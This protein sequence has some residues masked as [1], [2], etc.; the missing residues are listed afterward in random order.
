MTRL[1]VDVRALVVGDR[2]RHGEHGGLADTERLVG[3]VGGIEAVGA[4]GVEGQ[5]G[6]G[7]AV[8][9]EGQ[10]RIGVNVGG[11]DRTGQERGILGDADAGG[12]GH[13]RVVGAGDGDDQVGGGHGALVV[14]DQVRHGEHG[15][16]AD[17]Q[18]LVGR[19]GGIE[20]VGAVSVEGQAGR[21]R[22]IEREGQRRIGIDV[23]GDDR[24]GQDR[25]ILGDADAG[26]LGHRRVVGAGDGDDQVGGER[27]AL[28][29]GDR[30]RHGE[31]GGL[32]DTQRLVGR[33][34]GIEAVGAVS[35]E[36]QA[37]RGRPIEREGQRRIGIDVGGDDR[38]GQ[39]RG[40]LGD[41]DAGGLGHR[42][43]VGAGDGDDQFAVNVAP[44]SSVTVYGTVSTADWPTPSDW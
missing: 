42:R 27:G 32:A 18:R 6:R 14:G 40:I 7:R 11:D 15:G 10:R 26:G 36:G 28:V 12:L 13:R 33:V 17:T 25:G 22:P 3:R 20:A 2:V 39:D 8:E 35:V 29:V 31:H 9:R 30:V 44:W 34:G 1:A 38:T 37:G 19:V 16:L 4:V 23:G 21:G 41:A 24:T 43:V 5:A